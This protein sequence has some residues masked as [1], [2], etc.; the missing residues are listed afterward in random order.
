MRSPSSPSRSRREPRTRCPF[1]HR[2]EIV[3]LVPAIT[4]DAL[5]GRS[6][7]A[8]GGGQQLRRVPAR[9]E[10][11]AEGRRADRPRYRAHPGAA[12]R[13]RRRLRLPDRPGE[14]TRASG[15][16]TFSY[17]HG[18]IATIARHDPRPRRRHRPS[19]RGRRAGLARIADSTRRGARR[20]SQ[21]ARSRARCWSSNG[22]PEH[23]ARCTPAAAW[24]FC[25]RCSSIAGGRNVFADV[26]R[27]SVQPS[28]ETMLARAPEVILELRAAGARSSRHPSPETRRMVGTARSVPA[29]EGPRV[30][31]LTGDYLVVP[32]PRLAGRN[33]SVRARASSGR[34]QMKILLSWSSGKD[35]AW[36][37]AS[38]STRRIRV[39]S[40]GC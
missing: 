19:R 30:H 6:R 21:A 29:V 8:G 31:L 26:S 25:T 14:A 4:G 17:R 34:L 15:H 36:A 13:P 7:V 9:G 23:C 20:A 3:S 12:A 35:S 22:S 32:G 24:G 33:R 28:T 5:R 16:R 10:G 18:G 38:R 37:L 27:E 11:V 1:R 39:R 2:A 40:L